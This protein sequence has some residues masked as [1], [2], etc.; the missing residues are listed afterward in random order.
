MSRVMLIAA[1]KPLPLC[2]HHE[3]RTKYVVIE[4]KTHTISFPR[5]FQVSEHSYYRDCVD[6]LGF[7]MKPYQY[8]LDLELNES[9]LH[10][11]RIYLSENF[12]A[13]ETVE[14]WSIWQSNEFGKC[15]PHYVGTLADVDMETLEQFLWDDPTGD[16]GQ[17]WLTIT[18]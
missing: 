7:P 4:G 17:C 9:D 15:P 1:D 11:L 10:H 5:G 18:I 14:L 8:E 12:S 2:C 3:I 6:G 16:P 13:G